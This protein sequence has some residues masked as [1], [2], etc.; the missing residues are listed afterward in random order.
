[1]PPVG[2]TDDNPVHLVLAHQPCDV[3]GGPDHAGIHDAAS[4]HRRV[5]VDETDDAVR[6]VVLVEHL[7]RDLPGRGP[8]AD[9]EQALLQARDPCARQEDQPPRENGCDEQDD[10]RH[11]RAAP[12]YQRRG[13]EEQDGEDDRRG[14]ARLQQA[15]EQLAPRIDGREVV[16]VVVVEAQLAE[17][18]DEGDLPD[19]LAAAVAVQVHRERQGPRDQQD[20]EPERRQSPRRD[21]A[22]ED[23]HRYS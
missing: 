16:E 20:L 11:E 21:L 8:G 15:H 4:H 14:P 10:R 13:Q 19:R 3:G 9:D 23:Q 6:E 2:Q 5:V 18:R 1:L 22:V 17:R 12:E 7:A